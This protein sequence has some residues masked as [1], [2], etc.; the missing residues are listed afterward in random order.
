MAL[1]GAAERAR[2]VRPVGE[3]FCSSH[4]TPSSRMLTVMPFSFRL[5]FSWSTSRRVIRA[6]SSS[7]RASKMMISSTR[8]MNSGLNVRFTSPITISL[9]LWAVSRGSPEAKPM[10]P[11]FSMK[12]A[13]M[14]DVMMMMAFLKSM[15]LPRPSVRWPSSNTWSSTLNTSGWAFSISSRSTTE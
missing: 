8:L 12:R 4:I 7:V 13:P 9:T 15:V 5:A 11:F 6:R 14:F 3:V 1:D 10:R 2:A